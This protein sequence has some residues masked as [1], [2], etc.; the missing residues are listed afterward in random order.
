[1]SWLD[2][3]AGGQR[4]KTYAQVEADALAAKAAAARG[5]EWERALM[6][7]RP[8]DFV[9][10]RLKA[11]A[12][13]KAPW[14]ATLSPAEL[15]LARGFGLRPLATVSATCCFHLGGNW[16]QGHAEAWESAIKR[17]RREAI[18]AGANAVVDVRMRTTG[19]EPAKSLD[20]LLI[21]TAVRLNRLPPSADPV[22]AT[23]PALEFVRLLQAG[24]TTV[25]IAVGANFDQLVISC[26]RP[27]T[28]LSGNQPLPALGQFWEKTRR[29]AHARL[30]ERTAALGN[31]V[32]AHVHVGQLLAEKVDDS[33]MLYRASH[34]VVGTVIAAR[35]GDGLKHEIRAVVDM[36][37][38]AS[39]LSR[40]SPSRHN[41]YDQM[42]DLEGIM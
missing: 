5:V 39:P 42:P 32:L 31:G 17:L 7:H 24:I 21:G 23:V 18:A 20:F 22:I 41:A 29:G 37:D 11:A 35:L 30:R 8:P 9:V 27:P 3:I 12:T 26:Y 40:E 6:Q 10:D 34:I 19:D 36:R 4:A 14:I 28:L 16:T 13:G 25:G 38:D 15:R 1:M 33:T 2:K